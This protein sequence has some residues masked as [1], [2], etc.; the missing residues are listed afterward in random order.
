MHKTQFIS[1]SQP[2]AFSRT[3]SDVF[4]LQITPEQTHKQWR[5]GIGLKQCLVLPKW[6]LME[7]EDMHM[8]QANRF[9]SES[10]IMVLK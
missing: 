10:H 4:K 8:A 5:V 9:F 2:K 1:N 7:Y 6:Q 3:K